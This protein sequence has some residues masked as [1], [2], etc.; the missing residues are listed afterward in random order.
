MYHF[1]PVVP[2]AMLLV[3]VK[4]LATYCYRSTDFEVHRNWLAV[5]SKSDVAEWYVE[6][7][8]QWTLDYPPNFAYFERGL[9]YVAD[10]VDP[11]MTEVDNLCYAS[12]ATVIFQRVTVVLGDVFLLFS[13]YALF[14]VLVPRESAVWGAVTQLVFHPGLL[15]VDSIH[16]QYN[17]FLYALLLISFWFVSQKQ[18]VAAGIVFAVLV[19]FKHIFLYI[20]PAYL[21]FMLK[22]FVFASNNPVAAFATVGTAV[23]ATVLLCFAPF[24]HQ[25]DVVLARMFPWGRGLTHAYWAPNVYALYNTADVLLQKI[26][27]VE[28]ERATC[29]NTRGLVDNYVPGEPTHAVLPSITPKVSLALTAGGLLFMSYGYWKLRGNGMLWRFAQGKHWDGIYLVYELALLC[30]TSSIVFFTFSWH[31]HEKAILMVSIPLMVLVQCVPPSLSEVIN[32]VTQAGTLS[33]YPL[34]FEPAELPFK[35]C[36][37]LALFFV[38]PLTYPTPI[39]LEALQT[40]IPKAD[41]Q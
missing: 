9:A 20:A 16:F 22:R 12:E 41:S 29:V 6:N 34:L 26:M 3:A 33:L 18:L 37:T 35:V 23:A 36:L 11:A 7:T 38:Y 31:V 13:A 14:S 15:I 21:I 4:L 8:S 5:T 24:L 27:R 17:S 25:M 28:A 10:W 1:Y 19:C 39:P 32:N 30:A 2:Y 40:T